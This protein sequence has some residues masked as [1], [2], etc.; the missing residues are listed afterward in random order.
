MVLWHKYLTLHVLLSACAVKTRTDQGPAGMY[1]RNPSW[2]LPLTSFGPWGPTS[3]CKNTF[4][5]AKNTWVAGDK[6]PQGMCSLKVVTKPATPAWW[7]KDPS[8]CSPLVA[9][10]VEAYVPPMTSALYTTRFAVKPAHMKLKSAVA[11]ALTCCRAPPSCNAPQARAGCLASSPSL[12]SALA[13]VQA[14]ARAASCSRTPP[15]PPPAWS[16]PRARQ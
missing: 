6:Y 5:S 13:P 10:A 2:A 3:G 4:D 14:P 1:S 15:K 16:A 12:D 7:T 11:Q 8:E 9:A